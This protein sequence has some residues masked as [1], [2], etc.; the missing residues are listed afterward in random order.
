MEHIIWHT[1]MSTEIGRQNLDGASE[2]KKN[3]YSF[4]F[5][6]FP[7]NENHPKVSLSAWTCCQCKLKPQIFKFLGAYKF[8]WGIT[9]S[10]R[11]NI[12]SPLQ[13]LAFTKR[14]VL[15]TYTTKKMP[16]FTATLTKIALH[17][18]SNASFSLMLLFTQYKTTWLTSQ[19][20]PSLY[21]NY[22]AVAILGGWVVHPDFGSG[23][24]KLWAGP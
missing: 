2:M 8:S 5:K 3:T 17:W 6:I 4:T 13:T 1:I 14:F 12:S 10:I 9:S 18:R 24:P 19:Q 11:P 15:S 16:Y 20:W 21:I 23:H 7:W 22:Q